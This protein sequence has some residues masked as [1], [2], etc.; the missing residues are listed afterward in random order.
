MIPLLS[1]I[2]A[3]GHLY[4]TSSSPSPSEISL[5]VFTI[6]RSL[7]LSSS[8][9]P[10]SPSQAASG[11]LSWRCLILPPT[12]VSQMSPQWERRKPASAERIQT[13]CS[14][15]GTSSRCLR[16]AVELQ[17]H[18][19]WG[20]GGGGFSL[21]LSVLII[22]SRRNYLLKSCI[23]DTEWKY[24][25]WRHFF[26]S[27]QSLARTWNEFDFWLYWAKQTCRII[28]VCK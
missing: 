26:H 28:Q 20:C 7:W 10:S 4:H 12:Y 14:V 6:A 3:Q 24:V 17:N 2:G 11:L 16:G 21:R 18:L 15:E 13:R 27:Q 8:C 25:T 19:L 1:V 22:A 5:H 23:K 9:P